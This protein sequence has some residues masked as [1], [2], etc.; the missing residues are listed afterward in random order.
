MRTLPT[1]SVG[2]SWL[3][4][5][6]LVW[7]YWWCKLT[8]A[9]W[10]LQWLQRLSA[11]KQASK[12]SQEGTWEPYTPPLSC[13]LHSHVTDACICSWDDGDLHPMWK[14]TAGVDLHPTLSPCLG[15]GI[16]DQM[17]LDNLCL[18]RKLSGKEVVTSS[19][20]LVGTSRSY[21]LTS[22][23]DEWVGNSF[24]SLLAPHCFYCWCDPEVVS[25]NQKLAGPEGK[26]LAS[27]LHPPLLTHENQL[28]VRARF[29]SGVWRRQN[30]SSL[31]PL[32][33]LFC[34]L[35]GEDSVSPVHMICSKSRLEMQSSFGGLGEYCSQTHLL[36]HAQWNLC[37]ALCLCYVCPP[38]TLS[39]KYNSVNT[40]SRESL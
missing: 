2:S 15:W 28:E 9:S 31:C 26:I 33:H 40:D 8:A 38:P 5:K 22:G 12:Q 30:F 1:E 17:Y 18:E 6:Q 10:A 37:V 29:L 35:Y 14:R 7:S 13:H 21:T 39:D 4:L 25:L 11:S 23:Q 24:T 36:T 16:T 34:L 32:F 19:R 27:P 3:L 20:R